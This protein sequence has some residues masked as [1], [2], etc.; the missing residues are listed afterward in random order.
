METFP[1]NFKESFIQ[2]KESIIDDFSSYVSEFQSKRGFKILKNLKS[3]M[4]NMQDVISKSLHNQSLYEKLKEKY[5]FLRNCQIEDSNYFRTL[6]EFLDGQF[7]V[8]ALHLNCSDKLPQD[9]FQKQKSRSK[10]IKIQKSYNCIV[11]LI[12][13]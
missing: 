7:S 10:T 12:Q 6:S 13:I 9:L 2:F 3:F 4:E 8:L 1:P 11:L 5:C